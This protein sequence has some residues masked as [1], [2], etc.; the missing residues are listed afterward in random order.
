MQKKSVS[1]GI[2]RLLVFLCTGFLDSEN[3]YVI[4]FVIMEKVV[5]RKKV[6]SLVVIFLFSFFKK[7][8]RAD[9]YT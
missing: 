2:R 6:N 4:Y 7:A 3:R 8:M 1:E 9:P 5:V